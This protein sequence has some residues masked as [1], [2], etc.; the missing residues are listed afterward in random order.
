[1]IK[2]GYNALITDVKM[3]GKDVQI[4]PNDIYEFYNIPY[5][6][7]ETDNTDLKGFQ[8]ISIEDVI[9]YLM[10]GRG[11]WNYKPDI[12]LPK[13]FNQAIKVS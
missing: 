11:S 8:N 9:K 12:E 10:Q 1:M 6:E 3:R 4:S 5:Y 2:R 13:N 7:K